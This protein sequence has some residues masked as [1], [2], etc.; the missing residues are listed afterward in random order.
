MFFNGILE[1][2]GHGSLRVSAI[3]LDETLSRTPDLPDFSERSLNF[4]T[5]YRFCTQS[6]AS[7][8]PSARAYRGRKPSYSR[9]QLEGAKALLGKAQGVG[10][11]ARIGPHPADGLTA[12]VPQHCRL[13]AEVA[14]L[15]QPFDCRFILR[16]RR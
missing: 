8:T 2:A 16:K 5:E 14:M 1:G 11:V 13:R 6:L 15:V 10:E 9:K 7:R 3:H 4:W 12:G